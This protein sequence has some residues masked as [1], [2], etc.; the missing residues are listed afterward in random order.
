MALSISALAKMLRA[1]GQ[2]L[3]ADHVDQTRISPADPVLV[4]DLL[5]ELTELSASRE[6]LI[7]VAPVGD[8]LNGDQAML[9]TITGRVNQ[10]RPSE[11][12]E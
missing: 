6:I 9:G 5:G 8:Q 11:S 2:H 1:N 10:Y 12:N 3:E 4:A 7:N